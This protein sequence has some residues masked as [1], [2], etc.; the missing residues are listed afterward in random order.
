MTLVK[1][2]FKRYWWVFMIPGLMAV[3]WLLVMP[4]VGGLYL[5]YIDYALSEMSGY[6]ESRLEF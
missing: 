3:I 4:W 1:N 5:S 2:F 6:W